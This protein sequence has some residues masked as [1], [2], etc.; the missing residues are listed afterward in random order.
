LKKS[1]HSSLGLVWSN[2]QNKLT[3]LSVLNVKLADKYEKGM[4]SKAATAPA[5][6]LFNIASS[7]T[8][9][10]TSENE[11]DI[12][13]ETTPLPTNIGASSGPWQLNTA[14]TEPANW[15][16][17]RKKME[18][19]S[20]QSVWTHSCF[21]IK[22]SDYPDQFDNIIGINRPEKKNWTFKCIFNKEFNEIQTHLPGTIKVS[23]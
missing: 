1:C 20:K 16:Q 19:K 2:I 4:R 22:Y 18:K 9:A 21:V 14:V 11:W 12:F 8:D 15:S 3:Q 7:A 10:G 5:S 13:L 23:S 6:L 17:W